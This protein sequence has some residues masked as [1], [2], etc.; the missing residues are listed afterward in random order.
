MKPVK[1]L[2]F[3]ALVM[4]VFAIMALLYLQPAFAPD[5]S[6]RTLCVFRCVDRH[7]PGQRRGAGCAVG[8]TAEV[9]AC[10]TRTGSRTEAHLSSRPY[11][12]RRQAAGPGPIRSQSDESRLDVSDSWAHT[13]VMGPGLAPRLRGASIRDDKCGSFS[14]TTLVIPRCPQGIRGTSAHLL[15]GWVRSPGQAGG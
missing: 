1:S 15:A 7:R 14:D 10:V 8:P 11:G 5:A 3:N 13:G 6:A 12:L 4:V 9:R 2:A